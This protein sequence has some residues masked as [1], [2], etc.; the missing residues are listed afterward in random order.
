LLI[1]EVRFPR[2]IMEGTK[3]IFEVK[4]SVGEDHGILK[5]LYRKPFD[6]EYE[7][8]GIHDYSP[9]LI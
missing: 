1:L 8:W 9:Y 7:D 6:H 2:R 3:E 5:F 4:I